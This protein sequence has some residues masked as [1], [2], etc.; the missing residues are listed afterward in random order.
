MALVRLILGTG[1]EITDYTAFLRLGGFLPAQLAIEMEKALL[2]ISA[3][4]EEEGLEDPSK[5]LNMI[6]FEDFF[7]AK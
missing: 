2:D 5:A 1:R 3:R 6:V 7:A 4:M